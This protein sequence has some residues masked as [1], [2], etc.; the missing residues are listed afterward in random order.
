MENVFIQDAHIQMLNSFPKSL[1]QPTMVSN[2]T[3]NAGLCLRYSRK[4]LK[5]L[6]YSTR[7][8]TVS[9][10]VSVGNIAIKLETSVLLG[11]VK[12]SFILDL[13]TSE[14]FGKNYQVYLC[15]QL[16]NRYS[17]LI[18]FLSYVSKLTLPQISYHPEF[19]LSNSAA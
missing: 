18:L 6:H 12:L 10:G 7:F 17:R 2:S 1:S 8:L 4:L 5:I 3:I 9:V 11:N 19:E 15:F 14:L 16:N 13:E